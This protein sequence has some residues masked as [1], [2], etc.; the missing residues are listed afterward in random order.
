MSTLDTH[1]GARL[2]RAAA[3]Q[4]SANVLQSL[5]DIARTS[6]K[7]SARSKYG[8]AANRPVPSAIGLH[9]HGVMTLILLC[10]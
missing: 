3:R 5:A 6:E 10:P 1:V 7:L 4:P 8:I 9:S 2:T